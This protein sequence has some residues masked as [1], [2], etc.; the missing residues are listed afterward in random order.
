MKIAIA[1]AGNTLDS[2]VDQR[3]SRCSYFAIFDLVTDSVEFIE[4]PNKEAL[5][6]AGP[7]TVQLV[8]SKGIQKII[9]GEFGVKIK[10]ILDNLKIQMI[11]NQESEKSIQQIIELLKKS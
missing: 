8:A 10:P 2:K 7:A 11:V 5:N 6:G 9:S 1:S 4:N 3:F